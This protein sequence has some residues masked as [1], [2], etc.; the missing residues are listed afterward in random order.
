VFDYALRRVVEGDYDGLYAAS[1][2]VRG[3][4]RIGEPLVTGWTPSEAHRILQQHGLELI[5]EL[6][7][8][9]LTHR[10]LIGSDGKA[11]GR[12]PGLVRVIDAKV[13]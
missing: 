12:L 2:A 9:E 3:L 13:P 6:D 8:A 11:D 1:S 4:A 10:Y 5:R 7:E